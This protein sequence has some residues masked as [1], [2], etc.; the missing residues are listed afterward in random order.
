MFGVQS[1]GRPWWRGEGKGGERGMGHCCQ[2][3][4][5]GVAGAKVGDNKG[6]GG[7]EGRVVS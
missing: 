4:G 3:W 2:G 1:L 5:G 6:R 7:E